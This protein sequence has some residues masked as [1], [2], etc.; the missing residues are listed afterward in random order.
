MTNDIDNNN[1][2]NCKS[3]SLYIERDLTTEDNEILSFHGLSTGNITIYHDTIL[4]LADLAT[5]EDGNFSWDNFEDKI[6]DW[7]YDTQ[8]WSVSYHEITDYELL[9]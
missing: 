4:K 5:D 8:G 7:L 1:I 3:I 9:D 6:Y 2:N